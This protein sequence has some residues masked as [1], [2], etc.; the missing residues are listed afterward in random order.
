MSENVKMD[1]IYVPQFFFFFIIIFC[2]NFD[3][4]IEVIDFIRES[5]IF[6]KC[7]EILCVQTVY[8][9]VKMV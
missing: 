4:N 9:V 5:D 6:F 1:S 3:Q 8:E 7:R 2:F